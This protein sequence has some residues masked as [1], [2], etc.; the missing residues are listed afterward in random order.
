LAEVLDPTPTDLGDNAKGPL[1]PGL[2]KIEDVLN[3]EFT[4]VRLTPDYPGR[5]VLITAFRCRTRCAVRGL[6]RGRLNQSFADVLE[7]GLT[8][9]DEGHEP[10]IA[11]GYSFFRDPR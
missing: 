5:K 2:L 1:E 8:A 3:A 7:D 6:L 4:F 11:R 10:R 9:A